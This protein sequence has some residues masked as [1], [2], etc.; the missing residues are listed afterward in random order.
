M[1]D[2]PFLTTE[3]VAAK[4]A[5]TPHTITVLIRKGDFPAIRVGGVYR[6]DPDEFTRY[7]NYGGTPGYREHLDAITRARQAEI[8]TFNPSDK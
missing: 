1:D 7:I 2:K 8:Y 6:I 3:Q 5:V 4:L